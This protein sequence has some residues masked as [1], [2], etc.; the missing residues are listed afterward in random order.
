MIMFSAD[1]D[2]DDVH[3]GEYLIDSDDEQNEGM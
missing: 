1:D 2:D 3:R